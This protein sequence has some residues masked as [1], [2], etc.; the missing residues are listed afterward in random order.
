V[1]ACA[2]GVEVVLAFGRGS[3]GRTHPKLRELVRKDLFDF[4][5]ASAD[6]RG[7]DACFLPRRFVR[8]HERGR[9]HPADIRSD[10]ELPCRGQSC[11]DLRLCVG[12]DTGGKAM[13]AQ[14]K[15][16]EDALLAPFPNA[17]MFR[18]PCYGLCTLRSRK[19]AGRGPAEPSFVRCCRWYGRSRR[20]R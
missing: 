1:S 9:L 13:R 10:P 12:A 18:W 6:L 20:R 8:R 3:T 2:D 5:A 17:Y 15:G 14:I 4:G 11:D 19:R 16:T 7:Y